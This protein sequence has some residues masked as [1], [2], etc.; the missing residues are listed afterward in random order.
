MKFTTKSFKIT[1]KCPF[2]TTKY[3]NITTKR[4]R[5]QFLIRNT[6]QATADGA[7]QALFSSK[8]DDFT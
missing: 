8:H 7:N 3:A 6:H 1:T 4:L 5:I 2:F